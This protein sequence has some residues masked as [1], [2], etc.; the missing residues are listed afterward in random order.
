MPTLEPPM[1]RPARSV[2]LREGQ[3]PEVAA[4]KPATEGAQGHLLNFGQLVGS[5]VGVAIAGLV[6]LPVL[7]RNL[8]PAG[9]G[10]FSLFLMGL[11]VLSNLDLA[12]PIL[13]R[14]LA[15]SGRADDLTVQ[16]AA[17]RMD[18]ASA[19]TLAV[20]SAFVLTLVALAVGLAALDAAA[21]T[22]LA[23]SVL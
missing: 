21:A 17:E 9:Y 8:G 23:A 19:R 6:S 10:Q 4:E 16:D 15:R 1:T 2:G 18:R 22:A 11:G 20:T 13:V 5:Q 3:G 7:A 12:R 14:E